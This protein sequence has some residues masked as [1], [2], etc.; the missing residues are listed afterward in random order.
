MDDQEDV[1]G[2]DYFPVDPD[3]NEDFAIDLDGVAME[4]EDP[5]PST[6]PESTHN[7]VP[8]KVQP[9]I[10]PNQP[11]SPPPPPLQQPPPAIVEDD[12][13]PLQ[14]PPEEND[15]EEKNFYAISGGID[16]SR[17]M[18]L[19]ARKRTDYD[20]LRSDVPH[21]LEKPLP[22]LV[23]ETMELAQRKLDEKAQWDAIML[24][25]P[26]DEEDEQIDT[27]Q[28]VDKYKPKQFIDL[29]SD[30]SI[31][32]KF[33]V[34][35]SEWK[36]KGNHPSS[37]FT[38]SDPVLPIMSAG[39]APA[40]EPQNKKVMLIG[41]P[42]GV[43]KSALIEVCCRHFNYQIIESNASEDRGKFEMNKKISEVCGNRSVLDGTKPQILVIEEIDGDECYG[44]EVLVDILHKRPEI[45][46]RPII[47]VCT[48]VY[49]KSL[50]GLREM[51]TVIT[52][53]PPRGLRLAEKLKKILAH[54]NV[55]MESLAVDKLISVCDCDVRSCLNQLQALV[56]RRHLMKDDSNI[57]VT[58]VMKYVANESRS[59]DAA[60]KDNQ[61]S[62]LELM[63]LIF[64][65]KR[66]RTENY[67]ETIAVAISNSKSL[68]N[69]IADVFAHCV[70]TIPFSDVSMRHARRL[71]ELVSLG[72]IGIVGN[73]QLAMVYASNFCAAI[74]KPRIDIHNARKL[75]AARIHT[76][77][78]RSSV[79]QGLAKSSIHS[80]R[81]AKILMNNRNQFGL[82]LS[83]LLLWIMNPE[84]NPVWV[85][86]G[87]SANYCH[88][89]LARIAKIYAEF[90]I[91][92]VDEI[93]GRRDDIQVVGNQ[94]Y[95]LVPNLRSLCYG[96]SEIPGYA[97]GSQM[98]ET[99]KNQ[100]GIELAKMKSD[101][102]AELISR[103]SK[104]SLAPSP[105][106]KD[107]DFDDEQMKKARTALNLSA[108]AGLK[109][110]SH[111]QKIDKNTISG[112]RQFPFE[113]RFNE[114]HTN[115]VKRVLHLRDFLGRK[116]LDVYI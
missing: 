31:N 43:G 56:A 97:I 90:G 9:S 41:G 50:R 64:E 26:D 17:R 73:W 106:V 69:S 16:S 87:Q 6:V 86:K 63:E 58:D 89:E 3:D 10:I 11:S 23:V 102:G 5:P 22:E 68:P 83:R 20:S 100:I 96:E 25:P 107:D 15:T 81:A 47:C 67:R 55:K 98:G 7:V 4:F 93:V 88:P 84:H 109:K 19:R 112:L 116:N 115:A 72:D 62:E 34:W 49:K 21:F 61:K 105:L 74:G 75:I 37:S 71:G 40:D 103:G 95:Q 57:R 45:I 8:R 39:G 92:L 108:W 60:V 28:F 24:E 14:F 35:L 1:F 42:P 78:D 30:D 52:V 27:R 85:K 79:I 54:E 2:E 51:S 66:S 77:T 94:N 18:Y 53:G 29:V 46:K 113:F 32:R 99:L 80:S 110:P 111:H 33:L 38:I 104:R 65:P 13:Q 36:K 91:E 59:A 101:G 70:V 44:P 82:N 12:I 76:Q 114:G 48:D